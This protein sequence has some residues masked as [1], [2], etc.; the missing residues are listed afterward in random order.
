MQDLGLTLLQL[1]IQRRPWFLKSRGG[2][3]GQ[4]K[5]LLEISLAHGVAPDGGLHAALLL[6]FGA[7]ELAGGAVVLAQARL[8]LGNRLGN[9]EQ[10]PAL[11][12]AVLVLGGRLFHSAVC[13]GPGLLQHGTA[14]LRSSSSSG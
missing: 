7:E 14:L 12:V 11:G 10:L 13:G 8:E 2:F 4:L 3:L 6:P 1:G 5:A 9:V